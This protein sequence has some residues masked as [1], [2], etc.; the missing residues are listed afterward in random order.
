MQ[1]RYRRLYHYLRLRQADLFG[2]HFTAKQWHTISRNPTVFNGLLVAF[3]SS[4][5]EMAFAVSGIA[6]PIVGL[7]MRWWL[8]GDSF[9]FL[10]REPVEVVCKRPL[11][12]PGRAIALKVNG[13]PRLGQRN[14]AMVLDRG[15]GTVLQ[16]PRGGRSMNFIVLPYQ[17]TLIILVGPGIV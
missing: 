8:S 2:R 12:P 15:R 17:P 13:T 3:G 7:C 5:I 11:P 4:D 14:A 16:Y 6:I 1:V 10:H 9:W